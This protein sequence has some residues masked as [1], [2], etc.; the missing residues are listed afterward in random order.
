MDLM[1][2]MDM[3]MLTGEA[4]ASP[5]HVGA[6]LIFSP[7]ADAGPHYTDG[8]HRQALLGVGE[9]DPRL[10]RRPHLGPDTLGMWTWQEVEVDLPDHMQA[11]ILPPGS[12]EQALWD[13]VADLHARPLDRNRPQ[14]MAYL[15]DGLPNGRFAFYIKIHHTLVDGVEGMQMVSDGMSTD[16]SDRAV[17]PFY[18][19][20]ERAP[21]DAE[22]PPPRRPSNPLSALR[23]LA[24]GAAAVAGL[25]QNLIGGGADYLAGAIKGDSPLP[26]SAP[27]T[28]FNGRLGPERAVVGGTWPLQ[29]VR[30]IQDAAQLAF[31]AKVTC[32]DV[33]TAVVAGA[34]RGWLA[35]HDELPDRSLI[36]FCP[37]TV[38]VQGEPV[39]VGRGNQFG[40]QQC[41]L[42]TEIANPA[43]RLA[44]IHRSMRFA[45]DQVAR[46]GLATVLLTAPNLA[47]TLLLSLVP[48]I[49]KLRNG[50]NVPI[51]N[52]RGPTT[53]MYFNGAHLD[54][55]YPISTVFD[56]LGLNITM[57]SYAETVSFGYVAGANLVPDVQTLVP[58]TEDAFAELEAAFDIR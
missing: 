15:I 32:N 48:L 22:E 6:L 27:N 13:L 8:L 50:Y 37:I 58:F 42:G 52:V 1:A 26:L 57:C 49:P 10:R 29:R 30:A 28:R 40:L 35:A 24:E 20:T 21:A 55:L 33:L 54:S 3:A 16:S 43:E 46:H 5:M 36:A 51:S 11:R 18:L 39:Q 23:S 17:K 9:I 14:W 44:L 12:D 7:P 25:A 45:K 47:P 56:G 34:L 19:V 31:D 41:P 4:L 38:R 53:D 2:G